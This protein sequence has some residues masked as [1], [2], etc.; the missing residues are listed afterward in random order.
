M[1]ALKEARG[2][3][4][5]VSFNETFTKMFSRS[6]PESLD[7][8]ILQTTMNQWKNFWMFPSIMAGIILVI[9]AV[10]FWD[11]MKQPEDEGSAASKA[12]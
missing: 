3:K 5:A 9:F 2:E 7:T 4:A 11:K 8:E 1:N 10:T 12:D 6:L